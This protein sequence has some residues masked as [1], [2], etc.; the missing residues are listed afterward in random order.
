VWVAFQLLVSVSAV[1]AVPIGREPQVTARLPGDALTQRGQARREIL[2][3]QI[4]GQPH[5]V[6]TSS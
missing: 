6:S 2:A 5:L 4:A 3:G 1:L